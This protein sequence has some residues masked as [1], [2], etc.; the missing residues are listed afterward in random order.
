MKNYPLIV[1]LWSAGWNVAPSPIPTHPQVKK[2]LDVIERSVSGSSCS[3]VSTLNSPSARR[4][5][6]VTNTPMQPPRHPQ[7]SPVQ[8]GDGSARIEHGRFQQDFVE[9]EEIGSGQFGKVMKVH[10]KNRRE[11]E[12]EFAVKKSKRFEGVRHR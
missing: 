7:A 6:I 3:S 12:E 8:Q 2:T 10:H 1:L 11:G 4:G 5:L 9:V